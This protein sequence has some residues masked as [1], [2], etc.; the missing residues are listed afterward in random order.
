M[1]DI[2]ILLPDGTQRSFAEGTTAT[3]VAASIS[4]GLA[5]AAVAAEVDG[6]ETDLTA[7]L[8]DGAHLA[9]ITGDSDEGRHV[10]RHSTSH[11]MAQAVT[12]LFP[13]AKYSIGPAIADGF[14]YDFELPGDKTFTEDDLVAVEARMREIIKADQPFTRSEMS[15]DE[16]L[17]LFADQPYKCEIIERVRAL[18]AS[19]VDLEDPDVDVDEVEADAAE[20]EIGDKVSVYRN[21]PEFVDMCRGPHVPSTG[22]LGHFQLMKVA[23]AYWRGN[24]KGPMLQRIYGTAWES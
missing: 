5:K 16:A 9:I 4:R 23:G 1:A 19:P 13:G 11:V 20:I 3:D 22:R 7:P 6:H 8:A 2:N 15:I 10:L 24:E 12:Q 21:T 14:Y 17:A 18:A